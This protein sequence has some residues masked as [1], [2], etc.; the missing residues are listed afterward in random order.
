MS[1]SK[2]A[3]VLWVSLFLS[4]AANFYMAGLMGGRA[5]NP[6]SP[7]TADWRKH[8]E[9]LRQKLSQEDKQILQKTMAGRRDTF[10]LLRQELETAQK[11]VEEAARAM[12]FDQSALDQALSAEQQKK[13]ALLGMMLKTRQETFSQ[14]SPTGQDILRQLRGSWHGKPQTVIESPYDSDLDPIA[15]EYDIVCAGL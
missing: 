3:V 10:R 12:P 9:Q 15:F 8:D 6:A 14:I 7:V 5:F 4:L 2:M 1:T 13:A 11:A